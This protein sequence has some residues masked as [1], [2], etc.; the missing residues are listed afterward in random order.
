MKEEF[1]NAI[2]R[3]ISQLIIEIEKQPLSYYTERDLHWRLFHL[4]KGE[5]IFCKDSALE[6]I[7]AEF[8]SINKYSKEYREERKRRGHYDLVVWELGSAQKVANLAPWA[9]ADEILSQTEILVAVEMK[10]WEH[11]V[12]PT[13]PNEEM[14]DWDIRKLAD[15]ENKVQYA[16]F[17]NFVRLDFSSDKNRTYY[18]NLRNYLGEKLREAPST[19][20]ILC[21]PVPEW[22][23]SPI[24]PE[25][26]WIHR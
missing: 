11:N 13:K 10:C 1:L 16:Y 4:L 21:T 26:Y 9:T 2:E 8:P 20:K 12:L 17:L 23:G 18:E 24:D 14:V 22:R 3:C 7:H 19:L 6:L 25:Q 5:R 15:P